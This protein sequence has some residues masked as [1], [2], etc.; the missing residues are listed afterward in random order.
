MTEKA[1]LAQSAQ[2]H[3]L[4]TENE[5]MLQITWKRLKK[6]KLAVISLWIIIFLYLMA[7]FAPYIAPYEL[8]EMDFE[9]LWGPP[10]KQHWM[11]TDAM[12]RDLLTLIIYGSRVSL[13]VGIVSMLIAVSIGTL[14]GAIAGYYGGIVDS[15]IMRFTDIA[16]C[17]PSFFLIL[18]I[19]ALFGNGIYKVIVIIGLTSWMGVTRLVRGQFLSLKE[20]E[21]VEGARALGAN[22]AR[23]IFK[24]LLPNSMAPIIVASTLRIGSTILTE[25]VLSFLG[26]GVKQGTVSWGGIL[27]EAQSITVMVETPWV[28]IFPG[29]MIFITVLAFNLLGDGLRDALDPKLKQ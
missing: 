26:L 24:H 16:L 29:L 8:D 9:N 23:I 25:A 13:T 28:A 27:R 4:K 20:R 3:G 19:V 17:F 15:I 6:N 14:L 10:S 7:I 5:T 1:N 2:K 11:G 21:F 12:G 18:T 22:D